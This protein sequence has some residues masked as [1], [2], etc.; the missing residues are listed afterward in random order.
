MKKEKQ[1]WPKI[2]GGGISGVLEI[3]LFHPI[4][5]LTK[6]LMFN[7]TSVNK[8]NFSKILFLKKILMIHLQIN[9][10]LYIRVLNLVWLIKFYK[11]LTNMVVKVF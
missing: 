4:D 3:G 2:V 10:N 8:N 6:R 5:T 9:I 1:L 11:E 7:T